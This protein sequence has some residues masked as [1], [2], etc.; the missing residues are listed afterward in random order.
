M[1]INKIDYADG[2]QGKM[3]YFYPTISSSKGK[4]HLTQSYDVHP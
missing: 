1:V 4:D 2:N 3:S